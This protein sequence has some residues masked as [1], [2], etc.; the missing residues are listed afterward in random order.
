MFFAT[1]LSGNAGDRGFYTLLEFTGNSSRTNIRVS[2]DGS[3]AIYDNSNPSEPDNWEA[4]LPAGT[5][6]A[7]NA[8]GNNSFLDP[9]DTLNLYKLSV[10]GDFSFSPHYDLTLQEVGGSSYF[11]SD[12]A[13]WQNG[14][15]VVGSGIESIRLDTNYSNRSFVVDE[16]AVL[17]PEPTASIVLAAFFVLVARRR[18]RR[19]LETS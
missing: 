3:L 15:P 16:V 1:E 10:F 7:S 13:R 19:S 6:K 17:V 5:V 18:T 9:G 4:Q 12:I 2:G 8:G 11:V 14:I